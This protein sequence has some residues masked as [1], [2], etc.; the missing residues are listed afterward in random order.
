MSPERKLPYTSTLLEEETPYFTD[1]QR[2]GPQKPLGY[3]RLSTIQTYNQEDPLVLLQEARDRG[4]L[5]I[6]FEEKESPATGAA[7]YVADT[8]ALEALLEKHKGILEENGWPQEPEA[9]IR[10]VNIDWSTPSKTPLFDLIAD[11]FADYTNPYR[12]DVKEEK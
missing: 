8:Q 5:A 6:I 2:V 7:L 3:L 1:L 11:A 4:F 10:K 12:T 9:F